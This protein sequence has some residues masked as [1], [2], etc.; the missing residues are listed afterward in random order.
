MSA[1]VFEVGCCS[2]RS[3][4]KSQNWWSCRKNVIDPED[5]SGAPCPDF[6]G[7][8]PSAGDE[9]VGGRRQEKRPD[10]G[11]GWMGG[12]AIE[13]LYHYW[14]HCNWTS[15]QSL[16]GH[17]WFIFGKVT[18]MRLNIG[19]VILFMI[20]ILCMST[21][22]YFVSVWRA[23]AIVWM[24]CWVVKKGGYGGIAPLSVNFPR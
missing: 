7:G 17:F 14:H 20:Y 2:V 5:G 3:L 16:L 12:L 18:V 24:S 9:S 22:A 10:H 15:S 1:S 6:E 19:W 13:T 8:N 4:H 23:V 21:Y 11:I